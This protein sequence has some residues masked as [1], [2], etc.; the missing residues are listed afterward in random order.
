MN[1]EEIEEVGQILTELIAVPHK[2]FSLVHNRTVSFDTSIWALEC[3]GKL[4]SDL[5]LLTA[6]RKAKRGLLP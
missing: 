4:Y 5:D 3:N 6:L 2:S 1:P